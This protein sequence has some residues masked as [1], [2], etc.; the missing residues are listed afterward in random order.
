M[1]D[2]TLNVWA[3]SDEGPC[4]LVPDEVREVTPVLWIYESHVPLEAL[5]ADLHLPLQTGLV[6][7]LLGGPLGEA[8]GGWEDES[9]GHKVTRAV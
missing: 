5:P 8:L 6:A 4:P 9:R 7:G 3:V 2:Y 1:H